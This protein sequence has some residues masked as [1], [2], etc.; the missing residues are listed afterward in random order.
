[1]AELAIPFRKEAPAEWKER[2][3]ATHAKDGN[4]LIRLAL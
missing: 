2:S 1:M 3:P 4:I